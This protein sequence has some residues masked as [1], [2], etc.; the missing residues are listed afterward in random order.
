MKVIKD[1]KIGKLEDW[2]SKIT[3]C[4]QVSSIDDLDGCGALLEITTKDLVLMKWYG[5][6]F[7]HH[8]SAVRCSQCGNYNAVKDLPQPLWEALN[9]DENRAKA[10]FNGHDESIY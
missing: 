8:Y 5:T 4:K 9:T 1:G 6:H 10:I 3:C 2:K 7:C